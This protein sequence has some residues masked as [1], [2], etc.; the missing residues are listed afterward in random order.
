M[1]IF[2]KPPGGPYIATRRLMPII[3][4]LECF[5]GPCLAVKPCT[6]RRRKWMA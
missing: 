4:V 1:E 2:Q 5:W 6:A 3:W